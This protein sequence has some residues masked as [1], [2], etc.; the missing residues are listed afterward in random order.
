MMPTTHGAHSRESS[1]KVSK[2]RW[3][4][5]RYWTQ[6][7]VSESASLS[8]W[9]SIR[10]SAATGDLRAFTTPATHRQTKLCGRRKE[11]GQAVFQY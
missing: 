4:S 2:M 9:T 6:S 1:V 8:A 5:S 7:L 3:S 11:A 10:H